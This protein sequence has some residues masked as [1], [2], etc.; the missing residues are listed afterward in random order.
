MQLKPLE[1]DQ[2]D[3]SYGHTRNLDL[4]TSNVLAR[5]A[6]ELGQ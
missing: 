5:Q 1:N 4:A 6:S 3:A 2:C